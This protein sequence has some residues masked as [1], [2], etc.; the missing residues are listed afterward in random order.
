[1]QTDQLLIL[2]LIT[3]DIILEW[4]HSFSERSDGLIG[5]HY[6][7]QDNDNNPGTSTT[8][9]MQIIIPID[10]ASLLLKI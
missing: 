7:N 5:F 6:F 3:T 2:D 9:Y 4:D 1:M 10:L 8:P